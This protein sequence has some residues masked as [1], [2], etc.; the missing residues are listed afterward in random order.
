M[1]LC[2]CEMHVKAVHGYVYL[3]IKFVS[4]EQKVWLYNT[5]LLKKFSL[6]T[7]RNEIFYHEQFSHENIQR[8]IFAKLRYYWSIQDV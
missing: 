5:L 3:C 8:W 7:P 6:D 1:Y 2:L 4:A